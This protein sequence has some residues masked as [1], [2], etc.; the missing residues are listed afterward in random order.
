MQFYPEQKPMCK[1]NYKIVLVSSPAC[2]VPGLV[3]DFVPDP[4]GALVRTRKKERQK[5]QQ[6]KKQGT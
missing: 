3:P 2:L 4:P 6:Q 1:R 5:K